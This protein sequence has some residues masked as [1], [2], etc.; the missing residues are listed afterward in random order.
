[1]YQ[2]FYKADFAYIILQC[3]E[4]ALFSVDFSTKKPNFSKQKHLILD[5]ALE[6]LDLYFKKKI[7]HFNTPLTSHGSAFEQKVYQSLVQIPYGKTRTYQEIACQINHPKAFR[8]VANANAK[9]QLAIFI[10]CH[11]VVAKHHL[12]GYNGGVFIKEFL[13]KL[14]GAL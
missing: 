7:F 1:M 11:R 12:S 13:L 3:T 9:N 4:N 5:Q 10:P 6:E 14:E 2:S 8:A